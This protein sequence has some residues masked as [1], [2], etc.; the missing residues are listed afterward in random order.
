MSF[1]TNA[2]IAIVAGYLALTNSL[3][4]KIIDLLPSDQVEEE[5]ATVEADPPSGDLLSELAELPSRIR[6]IPDI[7][8]TN[9]DYQ[10]ATVIGSDGLTEATAGQPIEAIVNVFCTLSNSEFKR[11]T[12][13]T[14]FFIDADGVIMTNAHVA[15]F[16]LLENSD[17][18][19]DAEC[20]IRTGNP[21]VAQYKAEL[22]Y[23]SP[24]WIQENASVVNDAVPLGT[25]ERDYAL[26]Y[27]S[28]TTTGEPLPAQFPSL[29]YDSELLQTSVKDTSVVAAGYPAS[30]L[31]QSG[32]NTALLPKQAETSIS[33]LY[34]FGSNYADVF[35]IRGSAVGAQGASG[36]PVV[37]EEGRVIGMIA[38]RG[39]DV[40][41][42]EGSLRAITLSHIDRTITEETGF[43]L[44]ENLGGNL[45]HRSKVFETTLAPFLLTILEFQDPS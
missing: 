1:L 45:A 2:L 38:T 24:A 30:D 11:T 6:T 26:L 9:A 20:L 43:S 37:N 15:Q 3:A 41:D 39:D 29:G 5:V 12:T 8:R 13:G 27:V 10:Q 31:L 40:V 42:G 36:G 32:P 17:Q 35:A 7:L 16:L 33:E 23:L 44:E 14:G 21:A 34:T 18:Y 28:E 22:L 4:N 25:G 19:D